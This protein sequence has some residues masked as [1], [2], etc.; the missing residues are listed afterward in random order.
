MARDGRLHVG[1]R[2]I[3]IGTGSDAPL[4][5]I[6]LLTSA[7]VWQRLQGEPGTMIRFQFTRRQ[8]GR[9]HSDC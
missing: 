3:A 8:R 5:D 9:A 6:R 2:V 4:E 1:D 7:E